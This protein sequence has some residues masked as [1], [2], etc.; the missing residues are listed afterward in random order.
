MYIFRSLPA[1]NIAER[2]GAHTNPSPGAPRNI[3]RDL[4]GEQM[5]TWTP[6]DEDAFSQLMQVGRMKRMEAVRLY[7]RCRG[8]LNRAITIAA[9]GAPTADEIGRRA[10]FGENARLRAAERRQATAD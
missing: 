6:I 10:A 4:N 1:S 5:Q 7:R 3:A 2:L 9:A 8:N